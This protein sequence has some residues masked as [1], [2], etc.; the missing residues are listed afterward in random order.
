MYLLYKGVIF[1][2]GDA[3]YI[4]KDREIFVVNSPSMRMWK[5]LL[6]AMLGEKGFTKSIIGHSYYSQFYVYHAVI[7]SLLRWE[8]LYFVLFVF[9]K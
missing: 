2:V 3:R 8:V 6:L 5:S 7:W 9:L 4:D 1:H